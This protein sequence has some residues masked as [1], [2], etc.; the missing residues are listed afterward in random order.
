MASCGVSPEEMQAPALSFIEIVLVVSIKARS[1]K[2]FRVAARSIMTTQKSPTGNKQ[3]VSDP[4]FC[5][6]EEAP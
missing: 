2:E 1:T 3:R 4:I 5:D 6:T